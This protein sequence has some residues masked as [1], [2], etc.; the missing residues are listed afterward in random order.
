MKTSLK[1]TSALTLALVVGTGG[2]TACGKAPQAGHN[3]PPTTPVTGQA[4]VPSPSPAEDAL[5]IAKR[6][7]TAISAAV[8]GGTWVHDPDIER[9]P[10]GYGSGSTS[11][12]RTDIYGI[13][14]AMTVSLYFFATPAQAAHAETELGGYQDNTVVVTSW[15]PATAHAVDLIH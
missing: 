14:N 13:N 2:L 10:T 1:V 6:V 11:A 7:E 12:W 4:G 8:P 3:S 9:P 15:D 5:S